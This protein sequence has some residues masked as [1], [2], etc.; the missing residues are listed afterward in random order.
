MCA[1]R[2][3][4]FTHQI[5]YLHVQRLLFTHKHTLSCLI[6][7]RRQAWCHRMLIFLSKCHTPCHSYSALFS[8]N[9]QKADGARYTITRTWYT[10]KYRQYNDSSRRGSIIHTPQNK[11]FTNNLKNIC[12]HNSDI[13]NWKR[14][15]EG[16]EWHQW[17]DSDRG[18]G[19]GRTVAKQVYGL[20]SF[21]LKLWFLVNA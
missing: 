1:A 4:I 19:S 21:M 13:H 17:M 6:N 9:G 2:T 12:A 5:I 16:N 15:Y 7:H 8:I 3:C 20:F 18:H 14:K 11:I 10:Q